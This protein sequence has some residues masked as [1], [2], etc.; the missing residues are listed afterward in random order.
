M[1]ADHH[2]LTDGKDGGATLRFPNARI[3]ASRTGWEDNLRKRA[4]GGWNSY[5]DFAFSDF[6]LDADKASRLVLLD[7]GEVMPGVT[8]SYLGGTLGV[9]PGRSHRDSVGCGGGLQR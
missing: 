8:V 7:E 4:D 6:L 1:H 9:Q 3:Y 2:G 5:I